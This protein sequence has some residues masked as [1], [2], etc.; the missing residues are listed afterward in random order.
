MLFGVLLLS[1]EGERFPLLGA[2]LCRRFAALCALLCDLGALRGF[3]LAF[4]F[5]LQ[6]TLAR[7]FSG[8]RCR[9]DTRNEVEIL[10][11]FN[12][13][14]GATGAVQGRRLGAMIVM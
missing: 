14:A 12:L 7:G 10:A 2:L 1:L 3:G 13:F 9:A 4:R 6:G 11:A 8:G 5:L